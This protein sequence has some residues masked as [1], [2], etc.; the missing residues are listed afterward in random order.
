M[1][2]VIKRAFSTLYWLLPLAALGIFSGL[3]GLAPTSEDALWRVVCET[4][5]PGEAISSPMPEGQAETALHPASSLLSLPLCSIV[6]PGSPCNQAIVL[7]VLA[8]C[9]WLLFR[10]ARRI[11]GHRTA[12]AAALLYALHPLHAGFF[13]SLA[14]GLEGGIHTLLVLVALDAGSGWRSDLTRGISEGGRRPFSLSLKPFVCLLAA[15]AATSSSGNPG[16][17]LL[18]ILHDRY[19]AAPSCHE[20]AR[21]NQAGWYA[22]I[23]ILCGAAWAYRVFVSLPSAALVPDLDSITIPLVAPLLACTAPNSLPGSASGIA[24]LVVAILLPAMIVLRLL[25]HGRRLLRLLLPALCL[26]AA[27]TLFCCIEKDAAGLKSADLGPGIAFFSLA[28]ALVLA[29]PG[30][31]TGEKAAW[32]S[33]IPALVATGA[34]ACCLAFLS[35]DLVD[36]VRNGEAA[37]ARAANQLEKEIDR[38][39]AKYHYLYNEPLSIR[40]GGVEVAE[41]LD[42][43]LSLLPQ[44]SGAGEPPMIFPLQEHP[45][46]LHGHT[47]DFLAALSD[48]AAYHAD[49]E[50]RVIRLLTEEEKRKDV[51]CGLAIDIPR[52]ITIQPNGF[53]V[54]YS[55]MIKTS[56]RERVI[57]LTRLGPC[58]AEEFE[59]RLRLKRGRVELFVGESTGISNTLRL[60]NGEELRIWVELLGEEGKLKTRSFIETVRLFREEEKG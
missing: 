30:R 29:G 35:L 37:S 44:I 31:K 24:G 32:K 54:K 14:G 46:L 16:I 18:V 58:V 15:A 17:P 56:I 10:V 12:A 47:K 25:V 23:L 26:C 2:F 57:L 45:D 55:F 53:P 42:L 52:L 48:G 28:A 34:A 5:E 9:A 11:A 43:E 4:V 49:S 13:T 19:L 39:A 33:D 3:F 40:A 21:L 7:A 36:S 8:A 20:K 1:N 38:S 50:G 41:F 60:F 51:I 22:T 27:A 59:N 6:P